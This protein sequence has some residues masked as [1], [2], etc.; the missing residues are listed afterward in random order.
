M[1]NETRWPDESELNKL[2]TNKYIK[3]CRIEYKFFEDALCSIQ[4]F[5]TNNVESPIFE[6]EISESISLKIA[7]ID[8]FDNITEIVYYS[9]NCR[10]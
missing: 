10:I 5:F 7:E 6:T 8:V 1:Q 2:P 4:L 9:S 3:L